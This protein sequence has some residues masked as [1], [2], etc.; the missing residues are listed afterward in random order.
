MTKPSQSS[1]TA[2]IKPALVIF[3][4]DQAGKPKAGR[5]ASTHSDA[6]KEAAKALKLAVHEIRGAGLEELAKKIPVG[7]IHTRG[8]AFIPYIKRD[9]YD[10]LAALSTEPSPG[11]NVETAAK[12]PVTK[13]PANVPALPKDWSSLTIGH[14]VIA[15]DPVFEGWWEAVVANRD[16]DTLTLR[17]RDYPRLP[18]FQRPVTAVALAHPGTI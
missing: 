4:L 6:A 7:R 15:R 9:L 12:P 13:P 3:G 16:G 11:G 18:T 1:P 5:F 8:K 2:A 17:W 14:L 10:R